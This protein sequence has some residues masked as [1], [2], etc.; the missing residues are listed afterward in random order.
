MKKFI[1]FVLFLGV[2]FSFTNVCFAQIVINEIMYNPSGTDTGYEW[3]EVYNSGSSDVDMVGWKFTESGT[4]HGLT[5][6]QGTALI[7]P[8][9]FAII[10]DDLTKFLSAFNFSGTI[11]DST[12]SLSNDGESLIIKD[13]SKVEVDAVIYSKIQGAS[14]N[15]NSLQ[16]NITEW[17]SALPTP[18]AINATVDTEGETDDTNPPSGDSVILTTLTAGTGSGTITGK[19]NSYTKGATATL[20]AV[21]SG[22]ST[23]SGWSGACTNLSGT[24]S[25]VMDSNKTVTATFTSSSTPS[26]NPPS[27][28]GGSYYVYSSSVSLSTYEPL[29]LNVEAG[30]E[31]LGFLHT[32]LEFKAYSQDKKTGKNVSNARYYWTFGDGSSAEG[33]V[34][35]HTYLFAGTYNVVLNSSSGEEDA[36]DITKVKIIEPKVKMVYTDFY[37]EFINEN[38]T[39]LNIG[40]WK[41]KG[42]DREYLLPRDTIISANGNMKIPFSMLGPVSESDK[43]G[44]V[45]PDNQLAFE[46]SRVLGEEKQKQITEISQKLA[47]LQKELNLAYAGEN[48]LTQFTGIEDGRLISENDVNKS[49]GGKGESEISNTNLANSLSS[50]ASASVLS[51]IVDFF[52][53]MFR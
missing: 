38:T 43:L 6:K 11:F 24:C 9:S 17:I 42:N 31:R 40:G 30:R 34:V 28:G 46:T 18:G 33:N 13:N 7:P 21:A 41:I 15:G 50:G 36:V 14:E 47:M 53:G 27:S 48:N 51:K 35:S 5:V 26:T 3:I 2:V 16:K 25:V 49:K 10:V 12:F 4:D 8:G 39:D 44:V 37:V 1:L 23:F 20:T 52:A 19:E 22:T 29:N 45:Y 32:P